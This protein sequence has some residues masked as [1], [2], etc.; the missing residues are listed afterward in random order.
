MT[1]SLRDRVALVTGGSRGIGQGIAVELARAGAQ[2]FFT[3]RSS[4]DGA[5]ETVKLIEEGG[6]EEIF[7]RPQ[8]PYTQALLDCDPA[9]QS[10]ISRLLPTIPGELPNLIHPPKGCSFAARCPASLSRSSSSTSHS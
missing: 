5:A 1:E 4:P 2:V 7:Y 6:V 3:Y 9:R 10:D 8:H